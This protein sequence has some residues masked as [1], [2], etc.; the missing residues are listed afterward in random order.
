M[1]GGGVNGRWG[2]KLVGGWI[3]ECVHLREVGGKKVGV[4]GSK[5]GWIMIGRE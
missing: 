4:R 2:K 1:G 3:G 5:S